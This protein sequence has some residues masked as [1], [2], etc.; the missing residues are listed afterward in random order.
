MR[1]TC[2]MSL[3]TIE[4]LRS[5]SPVSRMLRHMC[6]SISMLICCIYA[7]NVMKCVN[8]QKMGK[9]NMI[10]YN[11]FRY[12]DEPPCFHIH[13]TQATGTFN[14][15]SIRSLLVAERVT[16]RH[17]KNAGGY[18]FYTTWW[19][20]A[21]CSSTFPASGWTNS[22][23]LQSQGLFQIRTSFVHMEVCVCAIIIIKWLRGSMN[24][25]PFRIYCLLPQIFA[26]ARALKTDF[27][28]FPFALCR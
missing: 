26:F 21:S 10:M 4:W 28:R 25:H 14:F 12:S 23:P 1:T 27:H 3:M 8:H 9:D 22:R 16:K 11:S 2:G 24:S 6:S 7:Q 19:S 17:W 18:Q 13:D 5:L 20:P 15:C